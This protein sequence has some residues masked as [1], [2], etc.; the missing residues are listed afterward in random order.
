VKTDPTKLNRAAQRY[1]YLARHFRSDAPESATFDLLRGHKIY[2]RSAGLMEFE[3]AIVLAGEWF[4][5]IGEQVFCDFFV[6]T[7]LPPLSAYLV[8]FGVGDGGIELINEQPRNLSVS[9]AFLLGG[10]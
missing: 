10:C 6:Q 2:A 1:L 8:Q 9:R 7:P 3:E 5:I 4:V